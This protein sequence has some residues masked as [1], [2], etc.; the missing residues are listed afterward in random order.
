MAFCLHHGSV[1]GIGWQYQQQERNIYKTDTSIFT[2][3]D[4]YL[5]METSSNQ[6]QRQ[7]ED[8]STAE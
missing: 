8:L 7:V 6:D 5:A 3:I 4:Q 1:D 2:G